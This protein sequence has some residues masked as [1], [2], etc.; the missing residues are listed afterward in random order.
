MMMRLPLPTVVGTRPDALVG[1]TVGPQLL[2]HSLFNFAVKRV[3][4]TTISGSSVSVVTDI[5]RARAEEIATLVGGARVVD[6]GLEL[7]RSNDVDAVLI[8]SIG[9]THAEFTLA[10]IAAGKPVFCEKPLAPTTPECLRVLEAEVAFGRRLVIVGFMRRCDPGYRQVK[11]SLDGGAIGEA[12]ILHNIHRNPTV[13]ESFTSFMTMTDSII[14]EVDTSRWLLGEEIVAVQ[15]I[16][17]KRTSKAYPHL[18]DPQF[19]AFTTESGVLSTVEFFANCQYGYDV[20]CELVGSEGTASLVNPVVAG[21]IAAGIDTSPVPLDWRVRFGAAYHAELQ[22][23]ISGLARGETVGPSAWDG[24]AATRVTEF[25]VEAVKTGE[26]L[27]I[28]Y[29][30]KPPLYV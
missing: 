20:R 8:A 26:R 28:D 2:G 11:A 6:D 16:P 7:I 27:T 4:A 3:P 9:E 19:A 25:G 18:Q 22:A 23:W 17:P 24:Y 5:N 21:Q 13:P 12:L 29:I 15:V 10:S 30:D 14:H 1:L